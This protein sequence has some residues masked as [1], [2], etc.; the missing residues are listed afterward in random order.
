MGQVR[1]ELGF[2]LVMGKA[3]GAVEAAAKILWVRVLPRRV[4]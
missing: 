4:D 2:V 1:G 3:S